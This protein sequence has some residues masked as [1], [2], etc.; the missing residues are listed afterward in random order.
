MLNLRG[1]SQLKSDTSLK[2]ENLVRA[3]FEGCRFFTHSSIKSLLAQN[4][5]LKHL[6]VSG[7][8]V[9]DD[10]VLQV[11]MHSCC[12]LQSLNISYCRNV[13]ARGVDSLV[14][15][16]PDLQDLRIAECPLSRET[17]L[18]LHGLH[19]LR[20]LSLAGCRDLV[21]DWIKDLI[22]GSITF[23]VV[24]PETRVKNSLVHLDLSRC[25]SLTS[26][27][28]KYL[29]WVLPN[30]EKLQLAGH[31]FADTALAELVVTLP[32]LSHIDLEDSKISDAVLDALSTCANLRHIQ[33][34]FCPK[35]SDAGI[36][37]LIEALPITH[38]D[39]DNTEITDRV[40]SAIAATS[41]PMRVSL[42]D[43]KHLSWTGVLSLLTANSARPESLKR[44]KTFYGWQRPVDGHTKRCQ[45]SDLQGAKEIE[46]EWA[47]YMMTSSEQVMRTGEG[48]SK[49]L[50]FD[51]NGLR[52]VA[53]ER[54][55]KACTVM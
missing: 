9:V 45:R 34:S 6:D 3:S 5:R 46:K 50:D 47:A 31:Q 10:D 44:I 43:C 21:D 8:T 40:L 35:I 18:A 55:A 42:Y 52:I 30:L 36:L 54:R 37:Q 28:T 7:L 22:Y 33:L 48:R 20:R 32:S 14:R 12:A 53:R 16:L 29:R 19:K 26:D 49:F 25:R 41:Q 51:D 1:C 13:T 39:L 17:I 11:M 23:G 38:L 15:K 2:L 24:Y 4:S 27:T